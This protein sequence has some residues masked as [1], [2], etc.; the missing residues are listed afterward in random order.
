MRPADLSSSADQLVI[1]CETAVE[2]GACADAWMFK[3]QFAKAQEYEMLYEKA[4]Q[5][6]MWDKGN[7][8]NMVQQMNVKSLDRNMGI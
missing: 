3:R 5:A 1:D 8:Q 6:L 4:I 7:E 2:Y